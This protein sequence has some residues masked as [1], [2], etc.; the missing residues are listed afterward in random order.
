M[1]KPDPM[2]EVAQMVHQSRALVI[3]GLA[4][5]FRA[6]KLFGFEHPSEFLNEIL[7]HIN[8][9]TVRE[10]LK[11]DDVPKEIVEAAEKVIEATET[12]DIMTALENLDKMKRNHPDDPDEKEGPGLYL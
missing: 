5:I 7:A 4:N 3:E 11:D 2:L 6:Y 1:T 9:D 10:M 12:G 8:K